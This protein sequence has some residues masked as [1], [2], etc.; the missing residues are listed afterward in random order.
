MVVGKTCAVSEEFCCWRAEEMWMFYGYCNFWVSSQ[1]HFTGVLLVLRDGGF[2]SCITLDDTQG[3]DFSNIID[4][5][6]S[7]HKDTGH[8][9]WSY[10]RRIHLDND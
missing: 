4:A 2:F 6:S 3:N 5:Y 9:S 8:V 10:L 1:P 7:D